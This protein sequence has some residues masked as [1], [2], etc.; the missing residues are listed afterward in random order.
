[1]FI[2]ALQLRSFKSNHFDGKFIINTLRLYTVYTQRYKGAPKKTELRNS[3]SRGWKGKG[4]LLLFEM[5]IMLQL[6]KKQI[7]CRKY[8]DADLLVQNR[9]DSCVTGQWHR[10]PLK[11]NKKTH[12]LLYFNFQQNWEVL[13]RELSARRMVNTHRSIIPLIHLTSSLKCCTVV[14]CLTV[15][16]CNVKEEIKIKR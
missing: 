5:L 11:Q 12:S 14:I 9:T 7:C 10:K 13:L 15:R 8:L 6:L 16:P 3:L 2:T 1:M 4:R